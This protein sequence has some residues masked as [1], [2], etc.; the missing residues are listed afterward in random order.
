M[1]GDAQDLGRRLE[2]AEYERRLA[3]LRVALLEAQRRMLEARIPAVLVISGVEGA[4][5]G[6]TINRLL[7]WMDA[8]GIAVHALGL[9]TPEESQRPYFFRF[10][11]RLPPA[12]ELAIFFGSWYTLPIA[13]RA[14][15]G[16][17]EMAFERSLGRILRFE[18]MLVDEGLLLIK[19][20]LHIPKKEQKR[21]FKKLEENP[22]TR[23]RVTEQDWELNEQYKSWSEAADLVLRRTD[24]GHAPWQVV[25][26]TDRRYRDVTA[27][28]LLLG[29]IEKRLARPAEPPPPPPALPVP[30]PVNVINQLDLSVALEEQEYERKLS[31]YQG[32]LGSLARALEPAA[33]SCVLVFEGADA[34]GKGGCIRRVVHALDARFYRVIPIAA[35]TDEERAL[36]YLWRFWRHLPRQGHVTVFDRSWYGRVL[37][38]RVEGLAAPSDWQRA[39][40]EIRAFEQ[41]LVDAGVILLK[42]WLAISPEEQLRRFEERERAGYKRY[43]I[44]PEDWRNRGKWQAYEAAASE[45]IERTHSD[46]APWTLVEAEDKRWA[47]VLVLRTFL[48]RLK[49]ALGDAG[50]TGKGRRKKAR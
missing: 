26:S 40:S 15:G 21:R 47:R 14:I 39:Y 29:A 43:K 6:E 4:G 18:R 42:F 16:E 3:P 46:E 10:W 48:D 20:W 9:P 23:W 32:R 35:P 33:R 44:T 36:P 28:E 27:A 5:K 22:D 8:R 2:K 31:R 41:Q 1:T 45:M 34:A 17:D 11:R 25:E 50:A 30:E 12:G 37:V 24:T 19:L 13:E 38:E 49:A 7:Q